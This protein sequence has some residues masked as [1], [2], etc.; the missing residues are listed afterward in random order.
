MTPA[1]SKI[2]AFTFL[3]ISAASCKKSDTVTSPPA[4]SKTILL[5]Q[6]SW[7]IQSVGIDADKNGIA[8][9]D[10]TSSIPACQLDNTYAFK[11]DSTGTM[12]EAAAKCAPADP[13]TKSFTWGFKNGETV[14]S[15]TF[16]FTDGDATIISMNDTNLVVA[17]DDDL[18]TGTTYHFIV[19]LK[20]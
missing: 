16:S 17:Y 6:A 18:G 10:V 5:T 2:L 13:Q 3:F 12:D 20:H 1:V 19:T 11:T 7:K 15:G 14:L 8:D 9:S 4:K